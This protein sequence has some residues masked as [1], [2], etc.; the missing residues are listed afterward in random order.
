MLGLVRSSHIASL[1]A[2]P[3]R[4]GGARHGNGIVDRTPTD[5]RGRHATRANLW[6]WLTHRRPTRRTDF[7]SLQ[8]IA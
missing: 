2:V 8:R 4:R 5:Y 7:V 6:V 3:T 1:A